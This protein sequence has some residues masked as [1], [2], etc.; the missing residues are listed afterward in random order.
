MQTTAQ[1]NWNPSLY[2]EK[3]A[4]VFEYGKGVLALLD[5]ASGE[6]ILDIGCGTGQLTKAIADSG[7]TVVGIDASPSMI[8]SARANFPNLEFL[9]ADAAD[10]SFA[11][12]FDAVFS[13][14]ALHWVRRAEEAARCIAAALKSGG[15]L[16][17]EF[18]GR[19]NGESV[20]QAIQQT[21]KEMLN[22]EV[23]HQWFFPSIGEYASLLEKYGLEVG[24]A[25]LFDRPTKL[26]GEEGMRNWVRMFCGAMFKE[27]PEELQDEALRRI[28]A[29][30]RSKLYVEGSWF[31]D[32][33]RLRIVA[34]KA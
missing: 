3:H 6:R 5:P 4:F 9:V 20:S 8:E 19:G 12:P 21:V 13:N 10:F 1:N 33:R 31:V 15:R 22:M 26:E 17:A 18:G 30:L 14:A 11:E 24:Q 34:R 25:S 27:V 32:Y 28:E 29:K 16:V 23:H 7:A 2:Q